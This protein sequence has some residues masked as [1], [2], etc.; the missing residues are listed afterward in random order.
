[1]AIAIVTP[2]DERRV[3]R[4]AFL[5]GQQGR[6]RA[7]LSAAAFVLETLRAARSGD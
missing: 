6:A 4:L 5:T 2:E 1:V 7:A 3:S